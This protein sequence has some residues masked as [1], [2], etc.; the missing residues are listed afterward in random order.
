VSGKGNRYF[1]GRLGYAR[2]TLL[3]GEPANDGSPTWR[4]LLQQAPPKADRSNAPRPAPK[5]HEL[6]DD[7]LDD[8]SDYPP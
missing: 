8:L 1:V 7:R 5:R 6:P 2:L 4:L 3:P